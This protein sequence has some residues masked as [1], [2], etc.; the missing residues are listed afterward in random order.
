[1]MMVTF[2]RCSEE[3]GSQM[4]RLA[5]VVHSNH[6]H[7][8]ALARH[9]VVGANRVSGASAEVLQIS[10]DQMEKG[11][12][13]DDALMAK[14]RAAD[15]VVF[16]CPTYMG[17]VSAVM[18]AFLDAS[19]NP[20][21]LQ[22]GWRDKIAGGF[23]NSGSQN[24]DKLSTLVQLSLTA[25]QHGMI[26]VGVADFPGNNRS[27]GTKDDINRM[28]AWIG[29]MAQSNGDQ[30]PDLTPS[31]GDRETAERYGQRLAE[32]TCQWLGEARFPTHR[33]S[34]ADPG[35]KRVATI[36]SEMG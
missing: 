2:A 32:V 9:I 29:A 14:V 3:A 23:T 28:G 30:G 5:I 16:G 33:D 1:M 12:W 36:G 13:S 18:K 11:R 6:G 21:W 17:G 10:G 34:Y 8:A 26:W 27:T 25:F 4:A 20:D 24:G 35:R 31:S 19:F 7:T 15:A 22:Q